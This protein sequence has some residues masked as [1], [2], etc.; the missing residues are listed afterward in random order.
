L[1]SDVIWREKPTNHIQINQ[2]VIEGKQRNKWPFTVSFLLL[3]ISLI[4]NTFVGTNSFDFLDTE[5][6]NSLHGLGYHIGAS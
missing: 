2:A 1:L 5:F 4:R 3:D 6:E